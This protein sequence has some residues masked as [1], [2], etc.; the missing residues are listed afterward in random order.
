MLGV[1]ALWTGCRTEPV[2]WRVPLHGVILLHDTLSWPDLVPDSLWSDTD[3]GLVLTATTTVPLFEEE[4]LVPALDTAWTESFELPFI[5]GPIPVAPGAAIWQ[6][7]EAIPFNVPDV[8]LRRLRLGAG[9]LRLAVDCSVQGP[10]VFRYAITGAEFPVTTNGGSE[11][12]LLEV[13]GNT[14]EVVLDLAGVV[15][16]LDGPDGLEFSRLSTEWDVIVSESAAEPVGIFGQDA[17]SLTV[18]LTGLEVAQVEG[19][20]DTQSLTTVDTV[21]LGPLGELQSLEVGWGDLE[22]NL[23]LQNTTGL[24]LQA[25]VL[26]LSRLDSAEAGTAST[27]LEDAAIGAPV[28]LS[29]A[30]VVGDDMAAWSI[31]PSEAD[32]TF[33]SGSGNLAGFLGDLP[34]ALAWNV[35]LALNPLGDVSGGFD[36]VDV[37]RLP[38]VAVQV[39]APLSVSSARAKWV[40]T[41]EV[42]PPDWIDYDGLLELTVE[43]SLPVGVELTLSLVDLPPHWLA[44]GPLFG[45]NWSVFPTV[46]V[47]PGGPA[48]DA[49]ST[50]EISLDFMQ[51][52]FE[53][54]RAG[55]RIQVDVDLAAG[56]GGAQFDAEQR[57]VVRGHLTGDAIISIQ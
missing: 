9:T 46:V 6:E 8:G 36:R 40:D 42:V 47:P 21:E 49:V 56:E 35:E 11:E 4:D 41:V 44:F 23:S 26:A 2:T 45:P 39:T 3:E 12:I 43:N 7:T 16:D 19:R 50:A 52:H 54:L 13:N 30:A 31:A 28:W 29:R 14:A 55:A 53:A 37:E 57:V 38:E 51:P 27:A 48:P 15:F 10:L 24:D 1:L 33:S 20:F 32:L 5:G 18:E 22:V 25:E 34:E 17:L